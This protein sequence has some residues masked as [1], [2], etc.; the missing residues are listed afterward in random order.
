MADH[1]GRRDRPANGRRQSG[2][3][4]R[5]RPRDSDTA[6]AALAIQGELLYGRN[7]VAEALRGR[8]R[9]HRLLLAEGVRPDERIE[10]LRQDAAQAGVPLETVPRPALDAATGGANHQGVGLDAEPYPYADLDD[11]LA[12]HGTVLMLD[13]LQDPQNIGTL[14]RAAEASGAAG[15]VLP[16]DRSASI[17]PAVVN[18]SAGAVELLA[19]AQVPNLVRAIERAKEGG[20]WT[21]GLEEDERAVDLFAGDL[22]TPAALIVGAEGPG[23]GP[24]LRRHCDVL[25]K[26]PMTGRVAS[27]NA[28]TAGAIAL[29]ELWRRQP[30]ERS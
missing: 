7:G 25:A 18:A 30:T 26:I 3:P 5:G 22:P 1:G 28:S 9:L 10:R 24:H 8:R 4:H 21:I 13:H 17:T 12:G 14:L 6:G 2:G 20:R 27:L 11:V 23:I 29:F 19:I 16:A 15:V